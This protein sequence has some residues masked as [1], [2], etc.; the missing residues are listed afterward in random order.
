MIDE[1]LLRRKNK[2]VM[3]L[4]SCTLKTKRKDSMVMA[5]LKN[6]E[7]YGYTFSVDV[8]EVIRYWTENEIK[9][10]YEELVGYLK[11]YCGADKTYRCMYPN[12][13]NQVYEM[14]D[15]ELLYIMQ[16]QIK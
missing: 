12:F 6:I 3:P 15:A 2:L 10:F 13:P 8:V 16:E 14:S 5:I 4:N 7:E 11:I 9:E 1:I